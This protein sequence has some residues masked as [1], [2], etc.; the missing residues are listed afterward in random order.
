MIEAST[1]IKWQ[2]LP[3]YFDHWVLCQVYARIFS[4]GP[5][6]RSS[7]GD[8]FPLENDPWGSVWRVWA[9]FGHFC[10]QNRGRKRGP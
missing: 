4:G 7:D 1:A 9:G 6:T 3:F 2:E 8:G 10:A 5:P